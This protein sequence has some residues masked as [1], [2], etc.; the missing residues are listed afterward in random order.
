LA[1]TAFVVKKD[2]AVVAEFTTDEQGRFHLPLSPG[3]YTISSKDGRAKFGCGPYEVEVTAGR[4][5]T[6]RWDC[7]SGIR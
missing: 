7:D 5:E 4:W 1:N 3:R 6:V 2:A